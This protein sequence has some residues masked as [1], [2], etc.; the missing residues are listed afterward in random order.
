MHAGKTVMLVFHTKVELQRPPSG[1]GRPGDMAVWPSPLKRCSGSSL[2]VGNSCVAPTVTVRGRPASPR[3]TGL[4]LTRFRLVLHRLIDH[5][6]HVSSQVELDS[7][8]SGYHWIWDQPDLVQA[9]RP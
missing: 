8:S 7:D 4:A 9:F 2:E 1:A 5:L 6:A 3:P